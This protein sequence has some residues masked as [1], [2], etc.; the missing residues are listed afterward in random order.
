MVTSPSLLLSAFPC[1]VRCTNFEQTHELSLGMAWHV[2]VRVEV[3]AGDFQG[4]VVTVVVVVVVM[5][6]AEDEGSR[7][8]SRLNPV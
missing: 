8:S 5:T 3:L 1:R 4:H 2:S 7:D 6:V